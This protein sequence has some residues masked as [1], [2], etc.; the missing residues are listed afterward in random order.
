[1]F[2]TNCSV[3]SWGR[4]WSTTVVSLSL[5]WMAMWRN[6][7][8]FDLV[9]HCYPC[10]MPIWFPFACCHIFFIVINFFWKFIHAAVR[11]KQLPVFISIYLFRHCAWICC[12]ECC[13]IYG[14]HITLYDDDPS[15]IKSLTYFTWASGF[16]HF[17][18]R[19]CDR[20]GKLTCIRLPQ[21]NYLTQTWTVPKT[22]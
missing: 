13:L 22:R 11:Y 18:F 14:C 9:I 1:M 5:I 16:A 20:L 2:A 3:Y 6:C 15:E 7:W 19:S 10:N 12:S 21:P 8:G 17:G 4:A